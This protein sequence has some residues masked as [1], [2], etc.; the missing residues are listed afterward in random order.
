MTFDGRS[1][2]HNKWLIADELSCKAEFQ[3]AIPPRSIYNKHLPSSISLQIPI[4]PPS[5]STKQ[6]Y[7][8]N[9]GN[10]L[11]REKSLT[12]SFFLFGQREEQFPV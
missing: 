1:Q 3:I 12:V 8:I 9:G 2:Q 6:Q 4:P 7:Q 10:K 5:P 11:G